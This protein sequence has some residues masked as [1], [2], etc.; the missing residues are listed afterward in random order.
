MARKIF[1]EGL[2]EL[3]AKL[4]KNVTMKDVKRV[5]RHNGSQMQS[6]IQK[7]ADFRGHVEWQK[8][9]GKT[10]VKPTGATKRSVNLQ[11]SAN[12]LEA[13][14]EPQT[15]YAPYVEWGTRFMSAQPF[16]RIGFAQQKE[17][18]KSDMKKLTE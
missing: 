6:K 18:F 17:K 10:F 8:G 9:K 11:I 7:N 2:E 12:G 3:D 4:K 13:S 15:E 5:V 16:V 1:F 14:S